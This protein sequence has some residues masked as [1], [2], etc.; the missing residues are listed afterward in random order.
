[1]EEV[2]IYNN[3]RGWRI[4]FSFQGAR[5][6]LT[7]EEATELKELLEKALAQTLSRAVSPGKKGEN[8]VEIV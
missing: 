3:G 4:A 1:M 8:N 2:E 7:V 5:R 6:V